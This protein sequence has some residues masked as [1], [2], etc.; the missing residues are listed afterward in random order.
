MRSHPRQLVANS[1]SLFRCRGRVRARR[2]GEER[3][4]HLADV[5]V[6]MERDIFGVAL[7]EWVRGS[8]DYET[9]ER[10]DG[11][12]CEGDGRSAYLA[13]IRE[14]Y[15]AE[16]K[17]LK[18]VRG[19]VL[20]VGCGAGRVSL[21]LQRRGFDVVGIDSSARVVKAARDSGVLQVWHSAIED[22]GEEL[23]DFETIVLYGNNFGM[24][25]TPTATRR[26]FRE[27]AS[28][29]HPESRILAV[30][31][32]PYFGGAPCVT[33]GYYHFNKSRGRLPGLLS[34]RYHYQGLVGPWSKWLFVSRREMRD[35][36]VGT[37]WHIESVV[38]PHPS[39]PYVA[40]LKL[41]TPE[42][43]SRRSIKKIS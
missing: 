13:P 37:G 10:D 33:R 34:Y 19:R 23:R 22:I 7:L 29:A 11:Y 21:E 9:F 15:D 26:W 43:T 39:E 17:S 8:C 1:L 35:M 20:D 14:W 42:R 40:V 27:W 6:V 18:L 3:I 16:R 36:L 30:S 38:A 4:E 12:F 41:D 5:G 24:L 28:L 31:T 32:S 25:G 2:S